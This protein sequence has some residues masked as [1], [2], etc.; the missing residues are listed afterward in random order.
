MGSLLKSISIH[1][2]A[3]CVERLKSVETLVSAVMFPVPP[4]AR[5]PGQLGDD[6]RHGQ[7]R[8]L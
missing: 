1:L 6:P 7:Q 4:D 2:E 3:I 5:G 8:T